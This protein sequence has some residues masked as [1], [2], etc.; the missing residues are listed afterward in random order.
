MTLHWHCVTVEFSSIFKTCPTFDHPTLQLQRSHGVRYRKRKGDELSSLT[1]C[2]QPSYPVFW[3]R[4]GRLLLR[5]Q[6]HCVFLNKP[7]RISN[8][9]RSAC[10]RN[11][12]RNF[13][14][15][16]TRIKVESNQ[17]SG[18]CLE[19]LRGTHVALSNGC[20]MVDSSQT[21]MAGFDYVKSQYSLPKAHHTSL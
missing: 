15:L 20:S 3:P 4:L 21:L 12:R 9:Y 5:T 1:K 19:T 18:D 13:C 14:H 8:T 16:H 7:F 17:Q 2:D 6:T 10:H 11:S